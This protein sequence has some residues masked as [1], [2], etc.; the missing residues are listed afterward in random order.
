M[1]HRT[2]LPLIFLLITLQG[3]D[4]QRYI[5]F[6]LA[7][8]LVEDAEYHI[9]RLEFKAARA[10]LEDAIK[11]KKGYAVAYRMLGVVNMRLKNYEAAITA[12]EKLFDLQP[13][14]S[15][16]A[17]Y[18]CAEAYL[19]NYAYTK[20]HDYFLLYKL[21]D[22]RDY[23]TDEQTAQRAYNLKVNQQIRNCEFAQK[24]DF[25]DKKEVAT[26]MGASVNSPYDEYLPT[27][28]SDGNLL[29]YTSNRK[30][31]DILVSKRKKGK[32]EEWAQ[33]RSI[34]K[35]INTPLNEGMAKLTACGRTLY[36]SACAWDNV[37]GGCDIYQAKFDKTDGEIS[38]VQ[39]TKG[40]NSDVWDSQPSISCDGKIMYFASTRKGGY[41]GTD[42]WMSTLGNQGV[43][44]PAVNLGSIVNSGG[45]EE[46]PYISADGLTLYFSSDGHPGFGEADI[47]RTT[48][49][50]EATT[51]DWTVPQNLGPSINTPFREAGIVLS[52]D[53]Q[54]AYFA[55]ARLGGK[56]GLDL[57]QVAVEEAIA[58]QQANVMLDGLVFDSQT[59]EPI[60]GAIIKIGR[61]GTPKQILKSDAN[62]Q[63]FIC[64]SDKSTYSYIV[65]KTGYQTSI[66]AR[67]FKR[68]VEEPTQHIA[69]PLT[70]KGS[71]L[72]EALGSPPAAP[73]VR[74]RKNLSVYFDSGM[75][76]LTDLQ[77]TQIKKL[78][79]QFDGKTK[80]LN[81]KVTG[82]ADDVGNRDFN[83]SLSEKRANYVAKYL[84]TLGISKEKIVYDGEGVVEG[85]VAKHQKRKVEILILN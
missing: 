32:E 81:I 13:S 36:F 22:D 75:Y 9:N 65:N 49:L 39:P 82:F 2:I 7:K 79:N 17:Y 28:T 38:E 30:T 34:G 84:E 35:E 78:I 71:E 44:N 77:K 62:G 8:T 1:R 53:G 25:T 33:A 3:V 23:K 41:G 58:P 40:L 18:E 73:K 45:D 42:I 6:K 10:K 67:Y 46:A 70:K 31:E 4:A 20:A 50:T 74:M 14:L 68:Q 85:N 72:V 48:Q 61:T 60:D 11:T 52:P 57:Y 83:Q 29:V 16:A 55:S 51:L 54:R 12:Y 66:E 27:L 59:G 19:K 69:I 63:F 56:G 80:N 47:F 24:I 21:S 37:R 76:E 15:R 64:L 5:N 26:N 43:W